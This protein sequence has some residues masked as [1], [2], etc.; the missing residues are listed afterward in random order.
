VRQKRGEGLRQ[1]FRVTFISI[2]REDVQN[3]NQIEVSSKTIH[4][5]AEKTHRL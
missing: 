1:A 2:Y 5:T 4:N 3:I